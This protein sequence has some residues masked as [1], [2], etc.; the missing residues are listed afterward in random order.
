[1]FT[2][3]TVAPRDFGGKIGVDNNGAGAVLCRYCRI[4]IGWVRRQFDREFCCAE[5]RRKGQARS[6]RALRDAGELEPVCPFLSAERTEEQRKERPTSRAGALAVVGICALMLVMMW[7]APRG[8]HR[9]AGAGAK[10]VLPESGLAR[11]LRGILPNWTAVRLRE[12]FS[13][14]LGDWTG[15]PGAGP[16]WTRQ[17]GLVRPGRLRLWTPSLRL[18]DYQFEFRGQ[19][20][21][22]AIGWTFRSADLENY[23]AAKISVTRSGSARRA[24]IVR[25]VVLNGRQYDRVQLPLPLTNLEESLYQVK[26]KVKG[27]D[28]VTS[29]NGQIVDTWSDRR[30]PR[31]GVGFFS[32]KGESAAIHWVRLDTAEPGFFSRLF[33]STL[34]FPP[35][36]Y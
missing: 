20:E 22:K 4:E 7:A 26:M 24:E 19:I 2:T 27:T 15:S 33:A 31:G 10:Y 17:N 13:A 1:M 8:G 18:T 12:N 6:A 32:D 5:H 29:V 34:F 28:F 36:A 11:S 30:L 25:Y 21:Q 35:G 23:Y 16:D 14:G 9:A 3:S